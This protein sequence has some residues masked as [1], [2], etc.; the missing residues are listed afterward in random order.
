MFRVARLSLR[1]D[2][3]EG[4]TKSLKDR[5]CRYELSPSMP[6]I[7]DSEVTSSHAHVVYEM[8]SMYSDVSSNQ[9]EF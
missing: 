5:G 8:A 6:L 1:R 4:R 2:K 9:P 7:I 3:K